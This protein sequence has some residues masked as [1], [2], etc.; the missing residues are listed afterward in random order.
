MP[1]AIHLF[2]TDFQRLGHPR[3]CRFAGNAP[4]HCPRLH[5]PVFRLDDY[6]QGT[7]LP[8]FGP[9]GVHSCRMISSSSSPSSFSKT[10]A[11]FA[12]FPGYEESDYQQRGSNGARKPKRFLG[13]YSGPRL[14][15]GP[16][17]PFY[18][19]KPFAGHPFWTERSGASHEEDG[20]R[21]LQFGACRTG[22]RGRTGDHPVGT[23]D[24]GRLG[25]TATRRGP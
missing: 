18:A 19:P 4:R 1:G 11:V 5:R 3:D 14:L 8:K 20:L 17:Q 2:W 24:H 22:V 9:G 7:R 15:Q 23:I 6:P 25:R 16:G 10:Y 12:P 21:L 13:A